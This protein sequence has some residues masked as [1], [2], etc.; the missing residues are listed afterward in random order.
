MANRQFTRV[1]CNDGAS[2]IYGE[3][4]IFCNADN[5]SLRGVYLKTKHKIPLNVPVKVT[6][7]HSNL[8]AIKLN[9]AVVRNEENGVGMQ[10]TNVTASSF[11]KLRNIIIDNT[12]DPNV[13]LLEMY[14][15]LKYIN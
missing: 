13:A 4:I 1:N 2:I 3:E 5:F 10:I 14:K 15:M 9:A 7:Y 6:I 11:V 12:N 8:T